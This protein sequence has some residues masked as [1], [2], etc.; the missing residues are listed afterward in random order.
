MLTQSAV[1]STLATRTNLTK[2]QITAVFDA[3]VTLATEEAKEKFIVPGLGRLV[4][5]DRAARTGRNPAT[6]AVVQI[7]AKRV[8]KF[9]IAKGLKD[10]VLGG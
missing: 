3:L 2:T 6:G 5:S 1:L 10:A 9:R 4:L 8:V 7:P